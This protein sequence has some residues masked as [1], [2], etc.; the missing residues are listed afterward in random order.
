MRLGDC[1]L[2]VVLFLFAIFIWLRNTA[3]ISSAEDTLPILCAVPL[4]FWLGSPWKFKNSP[5]PISLEMLVCS[6]I[7]FAG[8]IL[9]DFTLALAASWSLLFFN[10]LSRWTLEPSKLEVSKLLVLPMMAFPWIALDANTIGWW[11]RISSAW[12][13][14][15]FFSMFSGEVVQE[16]TSVVVDGLPLSVE[17]ACS[18][19][20]TLQSL[21][22]AGT[23]AAYIFLKDSPRFWWNLP[24]LIVMAWA[25]NT[26]RII[27]LAASAIY[28]SPEFALG[29][30]HTWGGWAILIFMFAL[31]TY[32][33]S[34]QAAKPTHP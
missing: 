11:F 14:A 24:L 26:I 2:I 19:L 32:I 18:G 29:A 8:G 17:A 31:C 33:F 25:A 6:A 20:N 16:G 23:C 5:L 27:A 15:L 1:L 7:L 22:I 12:I 13:T 34:R 28:I 9:G 4:F 21:L 10:L 30:F 3:W